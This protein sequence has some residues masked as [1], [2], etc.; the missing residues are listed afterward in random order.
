AAP[1]T[2]FNAARTQTVLVLATRTFRG[3]REFGRATH[4][5]RPDA[6][7]LA[8]REVVTDQTCNSCHGS[9]TAHGGRYTSTEQ[10]VLCHQ[11][12]GGP[13]FKTLVHAVHQDHFPQNIARCEACHAGAQ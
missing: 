2:G 9:L 12:Q 8:L 1:L 3:T 11:P 4:S 5:V 7:T 10:C 6:G 13:D